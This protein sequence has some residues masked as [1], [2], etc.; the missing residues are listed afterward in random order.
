M[1]GL[2]TASKTPQNIIRTGQCVLNLALPKQA[3][4]V[5]RLAGFTRTHM[6]PGFK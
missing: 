3:D 2:Q 5:D 6:V 4:A 1:L